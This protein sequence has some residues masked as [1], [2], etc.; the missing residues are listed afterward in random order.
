MAQPVNYSQWWGTPGAWS[1]NSAWKAAGA[2][3]ANYGATTNAL[4]AA[5]QDAYNKGTGRDLTSTFANGQGASW[6]SSKALGDL[7]TSDGYGRYYDAKNKAWMRSTANPNGTYGW[8]ADADFGNKLTNYFG[9]NTLANSGKFSAVTDPTTNALSGYRLNAD[10]TLRSTLDSGIKSQY[11]GYADQVKY[12]D[13]LN[14]TY[15]AKEIQDIYAAGGIE[16]YL[17]GQITSRN[18]DAYGKWRAS[19]PVPE[20]KPSVTFGGLINTPLQGSAIEAPQIAMNTVPQVVA[21]QI[22]PTQITPY[23]A[24]EYKIDPALDTVQGQLAG[25]INKDN[26]I[27]QMARTKALQEMNGRGLLNSSMTQEASDA[28][29][30]N[31]A[32]PIASADASAHLAA[33][34]AGVAARNAAKAAAFG[35]QADARTANLSAAMSAKVANATNTLNVISKNL[36][37]ASKTQ[38]AN[39]QS[40]FEQ[41]KQTSASASAM[42]SNVI[43]NLA[44]IMQDPNMD[45]PSKQSSINNMV[46]SLST[47]LNLIGSIAGMDFGKLL[48]FDR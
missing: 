21:D 37:T 22:D 33:G 18:A 2:K 28:A 1:T 14:K 23:Q 27:L 47:G 16:K 19:Q 32:T 5:A 29:W 45:A 34:Q 8:T 43:D 15:S 11:G 7:L 6:L 10:G 41:V 17:Q 48:S 36:D 31:A 35:A 20:I 44:R 46:A 24:E 13:L 3:D 39:I 26:P 25:L 30:Y 9:G 40:A 42:Y 38:L 12:D 4:W